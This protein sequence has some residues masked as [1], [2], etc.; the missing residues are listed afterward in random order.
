MATTLLDHRG[1]VIKT[2]HT[3]AH[4]EGRMVEVMHQDL[5]PII[6]QA[7]FDR[8]NH[9][10]SNDMKLVGYIPAAVVEQMMREGSFNDEAALKRWLN[11]PQNAC[12]RVWGG[13]V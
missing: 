8:E 11:D 2:L 1:S 5:T 12:F 10:Q 9:V 6:E 7:K 4:D 13:R 3:D